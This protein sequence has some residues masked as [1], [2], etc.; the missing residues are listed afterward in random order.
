MS[1]ID[2]IKARL[3]IVDVVS[4]YVTLQ[5]AGRNFK[6]PCPFHTEKTP[7]FIV[8]PE[9][10]S[11]HC[12]GACSMGGDAFKFVMKKENVEFREALRILAQKAGVDISE[13]RSDGKKSDPLY[14]INQLTSQFFQETLESSQGQTARDYLD[15]RG[16]DEVTRRKFGLG[17]SPQ[18]WDGLRTHLAA[19]DVNEDKSLEAG[20]L[21]KS[22]NGKVFDFFRGR[23]MF[24][25]HD[26]RGQV[27][28]FGGRALDDS[29]PKYLNT[30]QTPI[31]NKR[32]TLY[33]L[34]LARDS[35][36]EQKTGVVVEGYMD[37][38]AAHQFGYAN[39]VAS[40]GTA[41]TEQQIYQIKPL[42]SNFVYALDSD[43]A[44][45]EATQRALI[46]TWEQFLHQR[47]NT[48]RGPSMEFYY[49]EPINLKVA[50]ITSGKDPDELI[51]SDSAEWERLV[52]NAIPFM[53]YIIPAAVARFDTSTGQGKTQVADFLFPFIASQDPFDQ[54][55]YMRVLAETLGVSQEALR[56][57][58]SRPANRGQRRREQ[59]RPER[60]PE[61]KADAPSLVTRNQDALEDYALALLLHKP[62]LKD[63]VQ[64]FDPQFF[65]KT[66]ARELFTSWLSCSKIDVF[67]DSIDEALHEY[68]SLLMEKELAPTDQ[69][70]SELAL[71]QCLQRLE[72]RHLQELQESLLTVESA[73]SPPPRELEVTIADV[74]SRIKELFTQRIS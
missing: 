69:R 25:I 62:D 23:L 60:Q 73:D 18:G 14:Q 56:A 43:A 21:H 61:Q 3:D 16:V 31:F 1:N 34:H 35:I 71:A 19:L 74:N 44:G 68:F 36:R 64:E 9:R 28:G 51:R 57:S 66:E 13:S 70:E 12:F 67:R 72:R 33:A 8:N 27:I 52:S 5:K 63:H 47:V 54:E 53:E 20:V 22:E 30:G 46:A 37:V 48:R 41:L 6:A 7:S 65:R 45:Q 17:L 59:R 26:S 50:L 58:V 11:W 55:H 39:V 29:N 42:A 32:S 49:R 24:P 38:I 10:Q 15:K 2:D 40:M 4:S